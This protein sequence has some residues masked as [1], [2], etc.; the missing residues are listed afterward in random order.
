MEIISKC[1][2][3]QSLSLDLKRKGKTIGFVP[4]M[5]FL[6]EGHLSL[7]RE[8]KNRADVVIV[9]IF[10]NPTQFAPN[11]D[12]SRYPRDVER[13]KKLLLNEG[14]DYLFIP[15]SDEIY[16]DNYLTYITVENITTTLEGKTRPT[17]FRGV[18]TIVGMLFNL[19]LPDIAVFGQKDA[20]QVA[21][22]NKMVNDLKFPVELIIGP[23]IREPD[24]LA[25]SS[26]NV[27]LSIEERKDALILSRSI[28]YI[29]DHLNADCKI[30]EVISVCKMNISDVKTAKLDYLTVVDFDTFEEV[31]AIK[32]NKKYIVLIACYIG[33]TRLIDN[34]LIEI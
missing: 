10:V 19:I 5:G 29:K 16:T 32:K 20:Q 31:T 1:K 22:I 34:I 3:I 9:S 26:R 15:D 28:N 13:D 12:L 6:H 33:K 17:H 23:I 24:G 21:V 11:E 7:V 14:V 8:A 27:Y 25:M 2:E 18:S 4:T 30:E